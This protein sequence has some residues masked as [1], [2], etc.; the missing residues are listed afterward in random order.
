M[1]VTVFVEKLGREPSAT[2]IEVLNIFRS[3]LDTR[4]VKSLAKLVKPRLT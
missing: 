1:V 2:L 3:I 4:T